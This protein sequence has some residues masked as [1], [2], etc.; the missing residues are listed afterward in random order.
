MNRKMN[1][2]GAAL[3][4]LCALGLLAGAGCKGQRGGDDVMARVNGRKILRAE[5]E[6]YY[7]NQLTDSRCHR[8]SRHRACA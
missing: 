2:W 8:P 3:L 6:K 4:G 5:V 1:V 7:R